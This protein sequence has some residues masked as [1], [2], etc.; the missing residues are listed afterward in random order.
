MQPE[1]TGEGMFQAH[2]RGSRGSVGSIRRYHI[3]PRLL[4]GQV[5]FTLAAGEEDPAGGT[6]CGREQV[7]GLGLAAPHCTGVPRASRHLTN[8]HKVGLLLAGE[9][10]QHL[11]GGGLG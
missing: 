5:L 2:L 3:G 11:V 7:S 10:Q 1:G 8:G 6:H 4:P 9:G